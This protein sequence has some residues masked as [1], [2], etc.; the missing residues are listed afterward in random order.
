MTGHMVIMT[1]TNF[2]IVGTGLWICFILI[3]RRMLSRWLP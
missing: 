2:V 1:P 3:T